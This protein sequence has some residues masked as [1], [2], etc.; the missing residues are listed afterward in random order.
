MEPRPERLAH[1]QA[2]GLL[3]QDQERGLEGVVSVMGVAK[4]GPAD[5][6]HHRPMTMD[7]RRERQLRG[8]I[9]T[10]REPLEQL[11]VSQADDR[12]HVEEGA[13]LPAGQALVPV[14]HV[15]SRASPLPPLSE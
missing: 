6:E 8:L 12:P 7:Q 13:E 10:R 15:N 2:P 11:R 4:H 1:P 5:A 9:L 14:H 3:D